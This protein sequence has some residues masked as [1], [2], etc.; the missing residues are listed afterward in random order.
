MGAHTIAG[1]SNGSRG[2]SPPS[3]PHFNHV[4]CVHC[5][6]E[7]EKL[8]CTVVLLAKQ[9]RANHSSLAARMLP[10]VLDRVWTF[11]AV[12]VVELV[13]PQFCVF[14]QQLHHWVQLQR[15][16]RVGLSC[17]FWRR[18]QKHLRICRHHPT[19]WACV[20][21]RCFRAARP[22][23]CPSCCQFLPYQ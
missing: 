22:D 3:P 8:F 15:R 21:V 12:A 18:A 13:Q 5:S 9:Q 2:L 7:Y 1:G 20:R 23:Q 14:Y 16:S 10:L 11:Y 17:H 4:Y 6:V 19:G